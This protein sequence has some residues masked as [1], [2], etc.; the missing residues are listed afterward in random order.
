VW[1]VISVVTW[2]DEISSRTFW[3]SGSENGAAPR[4]VS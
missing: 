1:F 4:Y 3:D 2:R